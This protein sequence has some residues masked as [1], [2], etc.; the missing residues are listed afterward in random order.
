M[1]LR[2]E[3]GYERGRSAAALEHVEH[4][5]PQPFGA[6]V[7]LGELDPGPLAAPLQLGGPLEAGEGRRGGLRLGTGG[8]EGRRARREDS[9]DALDEVV[10]PLFVARRRCRA[11]CGRSS[12]ARGLRRAARGR[13]LA[14]R[15][16]RRATRGLRRATRGRCGVAG[17]RC[18]LARRGRGL[19]RGRRRRLRGCLRL[20]PARRRRPGLDRRIVDRLERR[21]RARELLEGAVDAEPL[22]LEQRLAPARALVH[23]LRELVE[24]TGA[25]ELPQHR[26]A[27]LRVGLE[28]P[29]ELVLR[30]QHHLQELVGAEREDLEQPLGD[31]PSLHRDDAPAR[32]LRL[33]AHRERLAAA[34]RAGAL[35]RLLRHLPVERALHPVVDAAVLELEHHLGEVVGRAEGAA[36]L[37][38][39]AVAV[40]RGAA[41]ERVGNGVEHARL[42]GAGAAADEEEPLVGEV[43]EVDGLP[44]AEGAEA[45]E[46]EPEHPHR[47]AS[48]ATS[49]S[50]A[51]ASAARSSGRRPSP[52]RTCRRNADTRSSGVVA[53]A[54]RLR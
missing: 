13:R 10:G 30:E 12:A 2:L 14:A 47:P 52:P 36:D 3:A 9:A 27:L 49:S 28:E 44:L 4:F 11:A 37:R 19:A 45:L 22:G 25:E 31:C 43:A 29:L 8:L 51:A 33:V 23:A 34:R 7:E 46:L 5:E 39:G 35:P 16:L 17:G 26:L 15:G 42:A 1:L 54:S 21:R 41:V 32:R 53:A 48:S 50:S 40:P 20:G 6:R 24:A 18:G 38:I